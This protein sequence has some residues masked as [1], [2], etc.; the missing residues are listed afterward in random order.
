M[1]LYAYP[2]LLV[3]SALFLRAQRMTLGL[4]IHGAAHCTTPG[5][6]EL[7]MLVQLLNRHEISACTSERYNLQKHGAGT[8]WNIANMVRLGDLTAPETLSAAIKQTVDGRK[9]PARRLPR[10]QW[11]DYP[12]S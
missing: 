10:T 1:A 4:L 2:P 12:A 11:R 5:A 8:C 7:P 6:P 9:I 3:G